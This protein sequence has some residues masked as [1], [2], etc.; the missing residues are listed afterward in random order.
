MRVTRPTQQLQATTFTI[1][2]PRTNGVNGGMIW[3]KK[4]SVNVSCIISS[5]PSVI[6]VSFYIN[7]LNMVSLLLLNTFLKMFLN[8]SVY[9]R[10]Q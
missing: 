8:V 9:L 7:L 6:V 3:P 4:C 1:L 2:R 5:T 10:N